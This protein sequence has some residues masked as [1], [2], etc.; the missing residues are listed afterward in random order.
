MLLKRIIQAHGTIEQTTFEK[1][2]TEVDR[3]GLSYSIIP[4]PISKN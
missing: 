3:R 2:E 4:W 1:K